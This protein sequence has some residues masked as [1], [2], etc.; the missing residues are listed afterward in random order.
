[1]RQKYLLQ[2]IRQMR[3]LYKAGKGQRAIGKRMRMPWQSVWPHVQDISSQQRKRLPLQGVVQPI[4]QQPLQ[5]SEAKARII[6][7]LMGDGYV[8]LFSNRSYRRTS[9]GRK[10]YYY[11]QGATIEFY[12]INNAV[13]VRFTADCKE[14]YGVKCKYDKQR[15]AIK[16]HRRAIFNDL[17]RYGK[18][19]SREW[20]IPIEI[21]TGSLSVKSEWLKAFCDSESYVE[22]VCRH[23]RIVI[24]SVNLAGLKQIKKLFKE[25]DIEGYINGN[26]EGAYRL[27][28]TG[29]ES[30]CNFAEKINFYH[31]QKHKALAR[32]I[33]DL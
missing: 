5:I 1:M 2:Q 32:M 31:S 7:Y 9:L 14:V 21:L 8:G 25:F 10:K 17:Q 30:L 24:C 12:N 19:G 4:P 15:A 28:I 33:K 11:Y 23:K 3:R 29:N 20:R 6:A 13:I 26:Y 18:F 16:L 27:R 22:N